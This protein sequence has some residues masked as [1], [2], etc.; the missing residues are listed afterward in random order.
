M[1][2]LPADILFSVIEEIGTQERPDFELLWAFY[3]TCRTLRL[4]AQTF[5]FRS[6]SLSF[7]TKSTPT[8]F[9]PSFALSWKH[10]HFIVTGNPQVAA[11]VKSL[12][13]RAVPSANLSREFVSLLSKFTMLTTLRCGY[14]DGYSSSW[15]SLGE[16]QKRHWQSIIQLPAVRTLEVL[17]FADI[18]TSIL[19]PCLHLRALYIDKFSTLDEPELG[20]GQSNVSHL[21]LL[22]LTSVRTSWDIKSL[23]PL[24][25]VYPSIGVPLVKKSNVNELFVNRIWDDDCSKLRDFPALRSFGIYLCEST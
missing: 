15:R 4:H 18:P 3:S 20:S 11:C 8:S 23:E 1:I 19:F 22:N 13:F 10:M 6:L 2:E 5:L 21:P 7:I 17:G 24:F 25:T 12:R 16:P 14:E 9:G